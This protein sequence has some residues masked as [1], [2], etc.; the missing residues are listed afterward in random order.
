MKKYKWIVELIVDGSI[1]EDGY[2][3]D[4][5]DVTDMLNNRFPLADNYL[6]KAKIIKRPNQ[7]EV[8]KLQG[9]KSVKEMNGE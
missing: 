7:K 3:P 2:N 6:S 1:V 9:Y 5:E 8:A 4:N